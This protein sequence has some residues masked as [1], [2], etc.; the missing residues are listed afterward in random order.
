MTVSHLLLSAKQFDGKIELNRKIWC[1]RVL[2]NWMDIMVYLGE[3]LWRHCRLYMSLFINRATCAT[4]MRCGICLSLVNILLSEGNKATLAQV[5][6]AG[7]RS[8][9]KTCGGFIRARAQQ[10]SEHKP[11]NLN[12]FLSH[13][14]LHPPTQISLQTHYWMELSHERTALNHKAAI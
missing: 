13:I 2:G 12:A 11:W 5:P 7:L 1:R 10:A 4:L 9:I 6:N 3:W 14:T 8:N